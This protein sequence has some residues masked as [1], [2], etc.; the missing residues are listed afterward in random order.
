[1]VDYKTDAVGA[2]DTADAARGYELQAG[3]YAL[4]IERAVGRPVKEKVF[5]FLRPAREEVFT[6][7]ARLSRRAES[8]ALEALGS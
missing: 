3:A 1:M 8:R 6:D 7:V 4:A 2:E 5:L